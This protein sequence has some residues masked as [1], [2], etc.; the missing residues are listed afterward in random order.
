MPNVSY[1]WVWRHDIGNDYSVRDAYTLLTT[2]DSFEVDDTS[3]LIWHKQVPVKVS[4]LAWRLL[5]NRLP[6]K[7]NLT[8]HNIIPQDSQM[9]VTVCGGLETT[10][11][12]FLS[13]PI[14]ASLWGSVGSW[15]AYYQ[16]LRL[17]YRIILSNSFILPEGRDPVVLSC[18]S[19]GYDA[20]GFFGTRGITKFLRLRKR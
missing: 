20:F 6:T 12:L 11:H 2:T 15:V 13:C 16:L 10:H 7:D 14:F 17:H 19:F 1:K 3:D 5:P 8:T 9:C 4:L 18:S